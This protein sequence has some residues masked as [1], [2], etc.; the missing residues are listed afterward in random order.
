MQQAEQVAV[1]AAAVVDRAIVE[2]LSTVVEGV[3][4]VPGLVSAEQRPDATWS[5]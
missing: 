5:R 3:H 4:L 1:G 2:G